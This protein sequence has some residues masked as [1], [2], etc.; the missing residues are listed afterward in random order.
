MA[1][2]HRTVLCMLLPVAMVACQASESPESSSDAEMVGGEA[3]PFGAAGATVFI[4][5]LQCSG[6]LL[7]PWQILTAGHC[8]QRTPNVPALTAGGTIRIV[9]ETG[10]DFNAGRKII[11]AKVARSDVHWS[12]RDA[13]LRLGDP[14]LAAL[15][16]DVSDVGLISLAEALPIK[17]FATVNTESVA[18]GTDNL[19]VIGGGCIEPGGAIPGSLRQSVLPV[20]DAVARRYAVGSRSKDGSTVQLCAGDSGGPGFPVGADGKP[21][22]APDGNVLVSAISSTLFP[23]PPGGN[24]S[25]IV[26]SWLV[27]MDNVQASAWLGLVQLTTK[28]PA[29]VA[30]DLLPATL[31]EKYE[32][33]RQARELPRG[34]K[35]SLVAAFAFDKSLAGLTAEHTGSLADLLIDP[36]N[37]RKKVKT[38]IAS[39]LKTIR[40]P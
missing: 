18:P 32:E 5:T 23:I 24:P 39:F 14:D 35:R 38:L 10:K 20:V 31:E 30:P 26:N 1:L 34:K 29:Q 3:V 11:D 6:V 22:K 16:N 25:T 4:G 19:L 28:L 12:W 17:T 33:I 8:L 36:A 7:S 21:K 40:K 15:D 13:L 37:S 9:S 27:R 2:L